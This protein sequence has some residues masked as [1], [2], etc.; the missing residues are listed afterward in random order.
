MWGYGRETPLLW[1][2]HRVGLVG[3]GVKQGDPAGPLFFAVSTF[4]LF[5]SIRDAAEKLV[6]EQFPLMPSYVGVTAVCDDLK[7]ICDPQVALP[8]AEVVQRKMAEAGRGLN[9]SKCR[10]LIHP[11]AADLVVWPNTLPSPSYPLL[12]VVSTGMKL[13]GAPIGPETF[14][15]DFVENRVRKVTASV[16]CMEKLAPWATWSLL[17]YCVNERINYLAQ[18][19]E[20]PL[21]QDSLALMDDIIDNA[22]LRAGG[23]PLAAPDSLAHLTMFTLR[24]LPCDLGGLGI[25]RFGGLAGEI[26]C[27]RGR[28]VL[29]EFAEKYTPRLLE[30]ATLDFWPPIVLGAAENRLWTEVA[31]L[32]RAE[33]D[34]D[35]GAIDEE[36]SPTSD[37]NITGVF[38]AFYL[39]SGESSPLCD[40]TN[41]DHSAGDRK[42]WRTGI[43]GAEANIKSEGRKINRL[44]FDALVQLL[45]SRGRLSEACWLRSNRFQRSG[46]WLAGPG[47]FLAN[48][49]SLSWAEYKMSLRIRL[50]RSPASLDVGD[51]E[52]GIL[53]RCNK[54][55]DL[56]SD[57]LHF[58][59]CRSSQ[60]QFI[61]RH[62]HIRDALHDMI[63]V[64]VRDDTP[65]SIAVTIEPLVRLISA[66]D[67]PVSAPDPPVAEIDPAAMD[68]EAAIEDIP[69]LYR[70]HMTLADRRA[71]GFEDKAAGQC[72]GDL[73]V[74]VD[75]LTTLL[76]LAV[77]DATARSYRRPPPVCP[78]P[79]LT[80]EE[81]P[82]HHMVP[83]QRRGRRRRASR[84]DNPP[85][86]GDTDLPPPPP[87][88]LPG[89]SFAIEHRV[90]EKKSKFRP[91]LGAAGVE[92]AKRFVAFVLEASGRLGP[93]AG[94]FLDYLRTL[95][96]FPILRFR[97][98]TSVISAKHNAQMALRWVRYLR[99]PI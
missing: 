23:L 79:A 91:F 78:P 70:A 47:G 39:A 32:F 99:R 57:P 81:P 56:H 55:V 40:F 43:R 52:G 49:T 25:R 93:D 2:G 77:A 83:I 38:R 54:R 7:V 85:L 75:S 28:T 64:A 68:I 94:A 73:G 20:F 3:T 80:S 41:P 87:P 26:A 82:P 24:S 65:Y 98:L 60:G 71:R 42:A 76:D 33:S 16:P 89:Q 19:T 36:P 84:P 63:G 29:Y 18:V 13:L 11:D 95:C 6:V 67:P 35:D 10:I 37:L 62:D 9:L 96:R 72:R 4:E 31:G 74:C 1:R 8:V 53:C 44:R 15:R 50:L 92:D 61:R 90:Y 86:G 59:H 97:A 17:R 48:S 5:E 58:F 34:D 45:H 51:A 30:G 69:R 88:R 27:L 46:C 66:P 14:R 22:I 12:P 21:V